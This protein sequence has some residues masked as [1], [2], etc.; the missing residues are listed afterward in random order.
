MKFDGVP[1]PFAASTP[2]GMAGVLPPHDPGPVDITVTSPYGKS[3]T[4]PN[5]LTYVP[6]PV[7]IAS[8]ETV[9]VGGSV[10]LSW[11]TEVHSSIDYIGLFPERGQEWDL[12]KSQLVTG[13]SGSMTFTMP[14]SPGRYDFRYLPVEGQWGAMAARSNVVTVIPASAPLSASGASPKIDR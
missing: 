4:I 6:P 10:T 1:A 13:N 7:L 2:I 9:T 8:P 12:L 11:V 14:S 5:A 3:L